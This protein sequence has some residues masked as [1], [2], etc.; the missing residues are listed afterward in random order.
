MDSA[1][2]IVSLDHDHYMSGKLPANPFPKPTSMLTSHLY[3]A[4]YWLW[5]GVGGQFPGNV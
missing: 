3:R 5:G 1:L 4:K 2:S